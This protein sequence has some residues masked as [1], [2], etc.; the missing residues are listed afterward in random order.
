MGN[1]LSVEIR[2]F[3]KTHKQREKK[4]TFST[5][6]QHENLCLTTVWEAGLQQAVE[7]KPPCLPLPPPVLSFS[8]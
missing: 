3:T 1:N 5:S 2:Q 4:P 7:G 6:H 8:I